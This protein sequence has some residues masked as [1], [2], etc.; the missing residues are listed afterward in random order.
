MSCHISLACFRRFATWGWTLS[1]LAGATLRS[2][3]LG[4]LARGKSDWIISSPCNVPS[5]SV[6]PNLY[7]FPRETAHKVRR[8]VESCQPIIPCIWRYRQ[9]SSDASELSSPNYRRAG[10]LNMTCL[11]ASS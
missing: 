7:G 11:S 1:I 3:K 5:S 9:F 6:Q 10:R 2:R 8:Y 4:S